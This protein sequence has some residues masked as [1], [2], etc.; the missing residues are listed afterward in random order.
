MAVSIFFLLRGR[1]LFRD[2]YLDF[3]DLEGLGIWQ[4]G[5]SGCIYDEVWMSSSGDDMLL[6]SNR[7]LPFFPSQTT[8]LNK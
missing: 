5:I 7:H 6:A 1:V 2:L 4:C 3:L 8:T